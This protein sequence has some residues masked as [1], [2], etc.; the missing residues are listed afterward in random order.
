MNNELHNIETLYGKGIIGFDTFEEAEQYA[1]THGMEV[2]RFERK[3]NNRFWSNEG[4]A[5]EPLDILDLHTNWDLYTRYFSAAHFWEYVEDE[6]ADMSEDENF[7]PAK[8]NEWLEVQKNIKD[9]IEKMSDDEF[10]IVWA[11]DTLEILP[12]RDMEWYDDLHDISY[13]IGCY[14]DDQDDQDDQDED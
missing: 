6:L 14:K 9:Q 4:T 10:A 2:V 13:K 1:A 11:N 12:K 8:I 5:Y 7:T 3:G